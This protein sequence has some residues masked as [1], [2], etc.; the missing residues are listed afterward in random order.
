MLESSPRRDVF[1]FRP[2]L[3]LVEDHPDTVEFMQDRLVTAGFDVEVARTGDEALV[4]LLAAYPPDLVVMDINLPK[5]DGDQ[6]VEAMRADVVTRNIPVIFV[7][8]DS[9]QR[10]SHLVDSQTTLF[11]EKPF[12]SQTLIAAVRSLLERRDQARE[13]DASG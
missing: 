5:I 4:A 10:V 7:T 1:T 13:E 11:L 3:L 9:A 8:A 12:S 2:R 6:L